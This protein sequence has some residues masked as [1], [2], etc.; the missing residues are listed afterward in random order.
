[1]L[2]GE[3][4]I[5]VA[6]L[7]QLTILWQLYIT[8]LFE[9]LYALKEYNYKPSTLNAFYHLLIMCIVLNYLQ[10]Y[11]LFLK[12]C[13]E[14]TVMTWIKGTERWYIEYAVLRNQGEKN[15]CFRKM[16]FATKLVFP[17]AQN[18]C[19]TAYIEGGMF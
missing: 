15:K 3:V 6:S 19:K 2:S 16:G 13:K 10:A 12:N 1:M 8:S 5:V 7:L 9:P 18:E 11:I 4:R 14:F 17:P